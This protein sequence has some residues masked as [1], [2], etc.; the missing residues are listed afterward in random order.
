MS[1][2][3]DRPCRCVPQ[4]ING[5]ATWRHETFNSRRQRGVQFVIQDPVRC[6]LFVSGLR[7]RPCRRVPQP[8][9][10]SAIWRHETFNS[11]RQR[12]VGIGNSEPEPES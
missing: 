2:L 7:D 5:S 8:I 6:S 4:P 3:R 12:G 11:R 10:G 1:G 9:N